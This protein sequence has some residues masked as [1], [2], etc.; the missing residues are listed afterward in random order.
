MTGEQ[1]DTLE[2]TSSPL[3]TL[4]LVPQSFTAE[5]SIEVALVARVEQQVHRTDS[6]RLRGKATWLENHF[7]FEAFSWNSTLDLEVLSLGSGDPDTLGCTSVDFLSL[8]PGKW[9]VL[10]ERVWG[11]TC[12]RLEVWAFV[13]MCPPSPPEVVIADTMPKPTQRELQKMHLQELVREEAAVPQTSKAS[14]EGKSQREL[15]RKELES[16]LESPTHE[17][18]KE[19]KMK[20]LEAKIAEM[21]AELEAMK[22]AGTSARQKRDQ[23][24][25]ERHGNVPMA[26]IDKFR[27]AGK[28]LAE[29]SKAE[30]ETTATAFGF[31][32][33]DL[34]KLGQEVMD[35]GTS[36]E[37]N[38]YGDSD[39]EEKFAQRVEEAQKIIAQEKER[40]EGGLLGRMRK[41]V[42][43][44]GA[45]ERAA[46]RKGKRGEAKDV[47]PAP[48]SKAAEP[49]PAAA[50]SVSPRRTTSPQPV[51]VFGFNFELPELLAFGQDGD[52]AASEVHN[53]YGSDTEEMQ[54]QRTEDAKNIMS[55]EKDRLEGMA[56]GRMRQ[57]LVAAGGAR[58]RMAKRKGKK[59]GNAIAEAA[60]AAQAQAG[61]SAAE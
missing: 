6:Q 49:A 48:K 23:K 27:S 15:Q 13:T 8:T 46:R 19:A 18:Q 36:E 38:I 53:V 60:Q 42:T 58:E 32:F 41:G 14:R 47:S 30:I 37:Y 45:R 33:E 51:S 1:A 57:G 7:K 26:G 3:A 55:Q 24:R 5:G 21:Q 44:G 39:N 40:M 16:L 28:R 43:A 52:D 17:K 54:A 59:L 29:P 61:P 22:S 25:M 31:N 11:S 34:F 35:E 12:G 50:T 4:E 56:R 2:T 10:K 9:H 20:S